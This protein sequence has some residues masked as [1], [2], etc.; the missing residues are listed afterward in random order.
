MESIGQL[1][2]DWLSS[3]QVIEL[4]DKMMRFA[5]LQMR[6]QHAAE[7][8]VQDALLAA[9]NKRDSFTGGSSLD[10][11]VF[12][13][14]RNRII[15]LLRSSTRQTMNFQSVEDDEQLDA[16]FAGNDHWHAQGKPKSWGKPEEVLDNEQFWQVFDICMN[17]MKEQLAQI[18]TMREFLGF[19]TDEICDQLQISQNN[20]WTLLHRARSRLRYCLERRWLA[21]QE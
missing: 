1:A 14:L 15:D 16:L 8:A 17:S 4:R 5:I 20:C 11:W 7:D 12:S 10:T 13:I 19:E 6:D 18:F 21:V 3:A 2:A 9:Y